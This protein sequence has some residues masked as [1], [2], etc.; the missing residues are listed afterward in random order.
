MQDL[1]KRAASDLSAS[2][3]AIVLTGA[4][5]S[6]ESGVPDFRG[7]KGIWTT[8][9]QAEA[10]AYQRY[11]RFLNDPKEYWEEMLGTV[12][13]GSDFYRRMREVEPNPGKVVRRGKL[14]M[15][16]GRVP[17]TPIEEAVDVVRHYER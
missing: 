7:P 17:P 16:T 8:N 15:W 11:E 10:Q 4:G 12:G 6:T 2:R 5:I 14:K 13:N 1:I 3:Y 9:P